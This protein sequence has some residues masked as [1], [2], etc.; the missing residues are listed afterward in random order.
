M[1]DQNQADQ[2]GA[3]EKKTGGKGKEKPGG[4]GQKSGAVDQKVQEEAAEE[5][6]EGGYQ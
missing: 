4:A 3:D 1:A 6:K 2:T 5:R